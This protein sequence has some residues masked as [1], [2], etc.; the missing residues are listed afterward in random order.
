M[1]SSDPSTDWR[2]SIAPAEMLTSSSG[3]CKQLHHL[4]G[5][6]FRQVIR[7]HEKSK[8]K[9]PPSTPL[10][11]RPRRDPGMPRLPSGQSNPPYLVHTLDGQFVDASGRTLLLRGVNVSGSSKAPPGQP[12]HVL[13]GLWES[14]ET[15][16]QSF[17]GQ[18]F[19]LDEADEHL[20]RLRS[21]GFNMLRYPITWEALEHEGP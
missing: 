4:K 15:G 12:S 21:W 6:P 13:N 14:A 8:D 20:T 18:P 11:Q 17:V 10:P 19:P 16:G 3:Q 1:I 7:F 5:N 2:E 9:A